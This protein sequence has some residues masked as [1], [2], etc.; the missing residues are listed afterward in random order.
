MLKTIAGS[1]L[2]RGSL[3]RLQW[4][5]G[6]ISRNLTRSRYKAMKISLWQSEMENYH[7][8]IDPDKL[9]VHGCWFVTRHHR[10]L[11]GQEFG[12]GWS[13]DPNS[14]DPKMVGHP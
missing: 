3:Q 11:G 4:T 7:G 5:A 8:E 12:T 2:V 14:T 1:M 6:S 10:C 9:S 13:P